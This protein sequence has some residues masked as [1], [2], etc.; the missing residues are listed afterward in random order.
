MSCPDFVMDIFALQQ[1]EEQQ[2]EIS[3]DEDFVKEALGVAI[4]ERLTESQR[5]YF[6]AYYA[7][8]LP[9]WGIAKKYGVDQSVVSRT[10]KRARKNLWEV[11]RFTHP[12]LLHAKMSYSNIVKKEKTKRFKAKETRI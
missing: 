8:G 2:S 9:I 6:L 10:I 1:H 7:D 12:R 4:R 5:K 3:E 11:M